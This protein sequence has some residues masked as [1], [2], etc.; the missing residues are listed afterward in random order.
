MRRFGPAPVAG[1]TYRDRPGAYAVIVSGGE[2][3]LAEQ[4]GALL[5]PGG[6]I[7]AGES[8]LAALHREIREETGWRVAPVRRLGTFQRYAWLQEEERWCRKIAHIHLCR[9]VRRLGPPV[10]PDHVPVWVRAGLAVD[11]LYQDGERV[12]AARAIGV[13]EEALKLRGI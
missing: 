5:L 7:E 10:E 6:G 13:P 9:A 2:V 4:G 8:V 12:F 3:L 11:L 1:Q